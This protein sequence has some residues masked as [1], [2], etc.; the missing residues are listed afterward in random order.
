M[1]RNKLLQ[2]MDDFIGHLEYYL[3]KSVA[4]WMVIFFLYLLFHIITGG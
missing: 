4:L 2:M 1:A 3:E